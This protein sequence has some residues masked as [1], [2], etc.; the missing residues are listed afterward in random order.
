LNDGLKILLK[1]FSLIYGLVTFVRN[2]L[3]D[4]Q[5]L[6]EKKFQIHTIG[7]GNLAVGGAGKTPMV[8][9]LIRLLSTEN[10]R[11]A[12]LSRGYKRQ[13]K[14]FVLADEN[15]TALDIGDEPLIYKSKYE[16][17]VAVDARR[18]NGVQQL[19]AM[20]SDAPGVILLDDVFQHRAIRCGLNILVTDYNNLFFNDS[21]LPSGT[22][23][24]YKSGM[25][26][27][28]VIVVSKTPENTTAVEIRQITKDINP[29]AHQ[30]VFYSYLKYGELY[31][32]TN[33]NDKISTLGDLFRY[34][35]ISFTGIANAQPMV[36]YLK[37][38][39]AEVSHLPFADH[40]D[41][42]MKDL[43]DIEKYY[44]G[45]PGGNKI[46]VTTEK[47]FMRLKNKAIWDFAKTLNIYV[48][49][50]EITFK[51]KEKEFDQL[52]LK[53]VRANRIYHQKYSR[54][55]Q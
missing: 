42:Q 44:Q 48:L 22:L 40:H 6:K 17:M 23:R 55:D 1:P 10:I 53:Y 15:S 25:S 28:D 3:Y 29:L 31:S 30:R 11:I 5:F 13:T 19:A 34:R 27:A 33:S 51:D 32:I 16:V 2:R 21:M 26:R 4:W 9:Y 38:Y 14:G 36:N 50:V 7:V 45:F 37:E 46:M 43:E 24:E 8:E 54:E 35:I 49:P 18:V 47:D 41:F 20:G 39:A 52:I 12:T